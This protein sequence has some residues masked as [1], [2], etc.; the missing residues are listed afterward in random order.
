[1]PTILR[2]NG[3]YHFHS[4][5]YM[6]AYTSLMCRCSSGAEKDVYA[7]TYSSKCIMYMVFFRCRPRSNSFQHRKVMCISLYKCEITVNL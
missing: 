5:L 3:R 6:Y 7:Y 4:L 1:M 2:K